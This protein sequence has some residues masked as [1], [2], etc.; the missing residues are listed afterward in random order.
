MSTPQT[1]IYIC[2]G[3]KLN[4]RYEHSIYFADTAGQKG[5]FAGKV[6]RTFP[7]YSFI[8]K[9]WDLKVEATMAEART[10]NY[11]YFNH[12][13]TN[14]T[15]YYFIDNIEYVSDSTV[16]LFLQ[17][18][19]IQ[20]YFFDIEL[21]PCFIERMHVPSDNIG[22]NT[23]PEN[24]EVGELINNGVYNYPV[25]SNLCILI[26]STI[27]PMTGANIAGSLTDSVFSG[28]GLFVVPN[29]MEVEWISQMNTLESDGQLD[30]IVN[31]WMY[32][33]A[34]VSLADGYSWDE[35][36][37]IPVGGVE[38][39]D[40]TVA[41]K[42]SDLA[43]YT[44]KN[45]KLFC[46]PYNFL[47]MT[48]NAGGSAVYHMERFSTDVCNFTVYGA[49][50]P[51]GAVKIAPQYYKGV[52]NN[53]DEG[54]ALG[55]YPAC[56]WDADM[57]KIWMA[58]NQNTQALNR[59]TSGAKI[60]GGAVAAAGSLLIGNVA[61]VVAGAGTAIS[62]ASQIAS[63]LAMQKD[64]DIQPPQARGSYSANVNIANDK[65]TFSFYWKCL[66]LESAKII[67]DYFTMYGYKLNRVLKPDICVR[68]GFT[69]I[70]TIGCHIKS[71]L[72]NED[73]VKI[74]SIYDNGITFWRNGDEI[75]NYSLDNKPI[76]WG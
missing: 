3:V 50:S 68:P 74:E 41:K 40:L 57:Y 75:G 18:D 76:A 65:Q 5:Y 28:M 14:K 58:Q 26:L 4:S 1:T 53:Y 34:L 69:Y 35:G 24:L 6:V 71:Y 49:I 38:T 20:T 61:G 42:Q 23:V 51:D 45:N 17:L 9:S 27:N 2:S 39:L 37:C 73:T 55:G 62:G 64:M 44:P 11:L 7:A 32:P 13:G 30:A 72:C 25:L 21:L 59:F 52:P 48:N 63:N 12:P 36:C 29:G 31:M 47:Y 66:N 15:W 67:D 33:E 8:R 16:R 19:V 22:Q 43:G 60:A 54:M 46:Y 70:K 10:W 56:A